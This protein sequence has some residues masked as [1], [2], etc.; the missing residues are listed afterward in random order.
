MDWDTG[1]DYGLGHGVFTQKIYHFIF[2][3]HKK[4]WGY[5]NMGGKKGKFFCRRQK[6]TLFAPHMCVDVIFQ[7][8]I[9]AQDV[10][11]A[12][13]L[14]CGYRVQVVPK[15]ICIE[16][17][18]IS[19]KFPGIAIGA[20]C[21]SM[22]VY[23]DLPGAVN[24][25]RVV[26]LSKHFISKDGGFDPTPSVKPPHRGMEQFPLDLCLSRDRKNSEALQQ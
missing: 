19:L 17:W 6:F 21:F 18:V 7:F 2:I 8:T 24:F 13:V 23:L 4:N 3:L 5:T 12:F 25:Q 20:F 1:L 22:Y 9:Q 14:F 15:Q 16:K 10:K 11:E 26:S